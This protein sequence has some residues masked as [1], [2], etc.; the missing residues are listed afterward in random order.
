MAGGQEQREG[1]YAG[2]PW[3]NLWPRRVP[4]NFAV[5]DV[6]CA[7]VFRESARLYPKKTAL[8]Y[9]DT[10][11]TYAELDGLTDRFAAFLKD[12]GVG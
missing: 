4:K 2:R 7:E 11:F 5:P 9:F 6:S 1:F 8:V 3:Y 12:L 10:R